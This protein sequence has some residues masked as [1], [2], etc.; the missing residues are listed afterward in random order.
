MGDDWGG[1]L[2]NSL[3]VMFIEVQ[4]LIRRYRSRDINLGS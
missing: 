3:Q 4:L 1:V 2:L